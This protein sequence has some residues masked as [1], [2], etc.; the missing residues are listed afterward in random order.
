MTRH[1]ARLL[2]AAVSWTGRHTPYFH[3]K[4]RW[5]FWVKPFAP[6]VVI[7]CIP[8]VGQRTR[9][10]MELMPRDD[11]DAY[12]HYCGIYGPRDVQ[13]AL[14]YLPVGGVLIDVGAHIGYYTLLAGTKVG[15]A[16]LVYAFEPEPNNFARLSRN[17]S[18]NHLPVVQ[19]DRRALDAVVGERVL[20]LYGSD[21]TG[22][23][24]FAPYQQ[25]YGRRTVRTTTLD[26]VAASVGRHIDLV[27]V[28]VEG[29]EAAVCRGGEGL[30]SSPSAPA[31]LIELND[32][33]LRAQ[34][35]SS[36]L[37]A[38]QLR[39]YGY[40]LFRTSPLNCIALTPHTVRACGLPPRCDE[41]E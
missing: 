21:N 40:R 41:L 25:D 26:E 15:P 31:L 27:K 30:L 2:D 20:Y 3:N 24:S 1:F 14:R 38:S 4:S 22:R 29:A 12:L 7:D 34:G 6:E 16:G 33:R 35:S 8:S 19:C 37:L 9:I 32:E 28:D 23:H 17:L 18:L 13:T 36:A 11:V 39:H 5:V 10:Y